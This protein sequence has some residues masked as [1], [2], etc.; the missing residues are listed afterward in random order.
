MQA[1]LA[2]VFQIVFGLS[3]ILFLVAALRWRTALY[4]RGG[5]LLLVVL[6]L[7]AFASF[8]FSRG[9]A[10]SSL[11]RGATVFVIGGVVLLVAA[12]LQVFA[13]YRLANAAPAGG[14]N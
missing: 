14:R 6:F 3:L 5:H 10:M 11:N 12:A 9:F 8:F 1:Y 7:F 13:V 2:P 4:A